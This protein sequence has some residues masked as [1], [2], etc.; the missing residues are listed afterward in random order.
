MTVA[1]TG[2]MNDSSRPCLLRKTELGE[3]DETS[4]QHRRSNLTDGAYQSAKNEVRD[5]PV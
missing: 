4:A 2:E 3:R 5:L 1:L